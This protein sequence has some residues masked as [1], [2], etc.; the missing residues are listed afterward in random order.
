MARK[1]P[2]TPQLG[3]NNDRAVLASLANTLTYI[4]GQAQPAI[5]PLPTGAT[6]AQIVDKLNELLARIQGS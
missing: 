5:T 4:T 6:T 1:Y 2:S 3:T